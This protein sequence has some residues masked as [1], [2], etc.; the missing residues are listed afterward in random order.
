MFCAVSH[1]LTC[2]Q[3]PGPQWGRLCLTWLVA[4]WD[5]AAGSS[6]IM[7]EIADTWCANVRINESVN[8]VDCLP[9][10]SARSPPGNR[11]FTAGRAAQ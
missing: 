6:I 5:A 7:L 2:G 11:D 10:S 4:A 3:C 8:L 9:P 1:A